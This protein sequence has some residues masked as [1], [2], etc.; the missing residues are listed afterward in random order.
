MVDVKGA[1]S[2][3]GV[4]LC[5]SDARIQDAIQQAGGITEK[6]DVN[7][8]NL[9]QR[10][11]DEMVIYIPTLNEAKTLKESPFISQTVSDDMISLNH[12]TVTELE[13][14]PGIGP[15]KAQSIVA[16]REQNGGFQS[17]EELKRVDGIGEKTFEQLKSSVRL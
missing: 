14:L 17:I 1:V 4:Y 11:T 9:S 12:A 8:V 6:G 3:P 15:K 5:P 16:Y 7:S 2:K 10:L 13:T